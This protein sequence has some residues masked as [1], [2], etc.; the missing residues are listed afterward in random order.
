MAYWNQDLPNGQ[1]SSGQ[2]MKISTVIVPAYRPVLFCE[3]LRLFMSLHAAAV[4]LTRR[5]QLA[6]GQLCKPGAIAM[7][8]GT[9][10]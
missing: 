1:P 10:A 7:C 2:V 6:F 3:K 4:W 5:R 8:P 9:L